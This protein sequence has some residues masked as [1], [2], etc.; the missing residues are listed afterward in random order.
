MLL[1]RRDVRM[2]MEYIDGK[3][4][5]EVYVP[6][7]KL[8]VVLKW[9]E[10]QG[11]GTLVAILERGLQRRYTQKDGLMP[12]PNNTILTS[13]ELAKYKTAEYAWERV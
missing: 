1:S 3:V 2:K 7:G 8:P 6:N 12:Q 10:R 9:F 11:D 4:Q 13:L 5:V